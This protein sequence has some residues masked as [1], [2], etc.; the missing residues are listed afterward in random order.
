MSGNEQ[1]PFNKEMS[2]LLDLL[3][4]LGS[5]R[6]LLTVDSSSALGIQFSKVPNPL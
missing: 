1:G 2:A 3:E 5:R 6:S 4:A